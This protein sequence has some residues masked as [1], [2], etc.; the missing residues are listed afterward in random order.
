MKSP[1]ALIAA[2]ALTAGAAP[3]L[4]EGIHQLLPDTELSVESF[5]APSAEMEEFEA[6]LLRLELERALS[7]P[8]MPVGPFVPKPEPDT[9]LVPP[10]SF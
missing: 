9:D 4:A 6:L 10:L 3:A 2:A 5:V 7:Y 8:G 1:F